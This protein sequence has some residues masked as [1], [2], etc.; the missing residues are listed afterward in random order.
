MLEADDLL[1]PTTS[2][3][4]P[5][6]TSSELW[7]CFRGGKIRGRGAVAPACPPKLGIGS[8]V[9]HVVPKR[10]MAFCLRRNSN[11]GDKA[12][13]S[14]APSRCIVIV[15]CKAKILNKKKKCFGPKKNKKKHNILEKSKKK[16]KNADG[17]DFFGR[18]PKG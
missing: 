18:K 6:L 1:V 15:N 16:G 14:F 4:W 17:I 13:T 2:S 7:S 10:K 12:K 3:C 9:G 8:L 11:F 5:W